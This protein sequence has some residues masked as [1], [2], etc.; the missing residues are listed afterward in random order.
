MGALR[1]LV[2]TIVALAVTATAGFFWMALFV[3][4]CRWMD[5]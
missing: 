5:L 3:A 1:D 4:I 2:V